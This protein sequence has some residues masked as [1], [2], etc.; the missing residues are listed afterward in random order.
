LERLILVSTMAFVAGCRAATANGPQRSPAA[1]PCAERLHDICGQFLLYDS[2]KGELPEKLDD[3]R[4]APGADASI[5]FACP[6][7]NEPYVYDRRGLLISDP[8]GRVV[9]YDSAPIHSGLRWAIV[10]ARSGGA[11]PIMTR[12]AGLGE[13]KWVQAKAAAE[14]P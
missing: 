7:S 5:A 10:I 11:S 8:P 6:T 3:L 4:S 13:E 12:V 1:D 9:V 2:L 14:A